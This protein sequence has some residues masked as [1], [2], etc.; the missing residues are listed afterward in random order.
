MNEFGPSDTF[1]ENGQNVPVRSSFEFQRSSDYSDY[2]DYRLKLD[3]ETM[4]V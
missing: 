1:P 4:E 3:L 2:S